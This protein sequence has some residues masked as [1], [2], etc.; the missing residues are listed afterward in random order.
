MTA[1]PRPSTAPD[2]SP[3]PARR[4]GAAL[5]AGLVLAALAGLWLVGRLAGG[6][7]PDELALAMPGGE[8][9]LPSPRLG[10]PEP[11]LAILPA[12][13]GEPELIDALSLEEFLDL[14]EKRVPPD[15]VKGVS[16]ELA[17]RPAIV[18][19]WRRYV[20][21]RG[22]K[23]D[24]REIL[25]VLARLPQ[26]QA[27]VAKLGSDPR[28]SAAFADLLKDPR[29]EATVRPDL[30]QGPAGAS[31]VAIAREWQRLAKSG[32]RVAD[33]TFMSGGGL[34]PGES[35]SGALNLK[36]DRERRS[37]AGPEAH[38]VG[39]LDQA[40]KTRQV[41]DG[42][43]SA[44]QTYRDADRKWITKFL[45][46]LKPDS[47]RIAIQTQLESGGDDL[48]GACFAS[49]NFALCRSVCDQVPEARCE[50]KSAYEACRSSGLRGPLD[51]V[52]A[53]LD[54]GP[55]S[56]EDQIDGRE[57]Q[58][59]C[60]TGN[61]SPPLSQAECPSSLDWGPQV[62][63]SGGCWQPSGSLG[64]AAR[65][66]PSAAGTG[67]ATATGGATGTTA[68]GSR[69]NTA[70][71]TATRTA[72]S[73]RTRTNTGTATRTGTGT[74][75]G[76]CYLCSVACMTPDPCPVCGPGKRHGACQNDFYS[77]SFL[78]GSRQCVGRPAHAVCNGRVVCSATG[79]GRCGGN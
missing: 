54:G 37:K 39:P 64:G 58:A 47:A 48:W 32:V 72:S 7:R 9:R 73:T 57:W 65:S 17:S 20:R 49:G 3:A 78:S 51:C 70:T 23:N 28:V 1:E 40:F 21:K 71:A 68:T 33:S 59:L 69:T 25:D 18:D 38:D 42:D 27:A 15:V 10:A 11:A 63:D 79:A 41:G 43:T 26:F 31:P 12:A 61:A 8:A 35:R 62:C 16:E 6:R 34:G 29:I 30:E 22:K 53:C 14:L 56:C 67:T 13:E 77:S 4:S 45:A 36:L 52:R 24:A 46:A 44:E 2:G 5:A 60:K 19:A 75:T 74:G 50:N 76:G 55:E 66:G